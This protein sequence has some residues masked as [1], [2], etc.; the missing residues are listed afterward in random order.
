MLRIVF[1][2]YLSICA[3]S[4]RAEGVTVFAASSLKTALDQIAQ[5]YLAETGV[6]VTTVYAASPVLARQIAAGAPGD[7]YIS[8][9]PAWMDW[10]ASQGAVE[11]AS[12]RD[13]IG[14]GLVLIAHGDAASQDSL[15]DIAGLLDGQRLA[16]A[17]TRAVP[18]GIYAKAALDWAGAPDDLPLAE[19]ANVRAAL[20]L[21][22]RGEAPLGIVYA[23]DAAAEPRVSTLYRFPSEAHELITY[24]AALTTDASATALAF[25][26]HLSGTSATQRFVVNGFA[27][28]P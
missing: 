26:D 11:E 1:A 24:P 6:K 10:A 15:P 4:A 12:R 17:L 21:V 22:A 8:A 19:A 7:I 13:I 18:A 16:V 23:S 9:N 28:L 14:N 5:D 2:I 20:A 27:P 25:L 3:L